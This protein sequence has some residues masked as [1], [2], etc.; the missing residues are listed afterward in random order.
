MS[1][2]WKE[3]YLALKTKYRD[4]KKEHKLLNQ[5]VTAERDAIYGDNVATHNK[6]HIQLKKMAE[7]MFEFQGLARKLHNNSSVRDCPL[8]KQHFKFK[9]ERTNG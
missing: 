2:D 5:V 8:C 9:K 1:I 4:L 7:V 3:R 6:V